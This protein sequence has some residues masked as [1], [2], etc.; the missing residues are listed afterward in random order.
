VASAF[1]G[2]HRGVK[3]LST[4]NVVLALFLV[5]FVFVAGP[6]KFILDAWPNALGDYLADLTNISSAT[7]AFGGADWMSEWTIFYW[8]WWLSWAPFVGTFIARISR[9]RTIRQFIVGVLL[10]PS[11]ASTLWFAM[12][13]TAIWKQA[14]GT[15]FSDSLAKGEEF[16]LFAMLESMPLYSLVSGLSMVLVAM[17]PGR[18]PQARRRGGRDADRPLEPVGSRAHAPRQR[19]RAPD[20]DRGAGTGPLV[21]GV[22]LR[23]KELS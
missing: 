10:I 5:V 12:G 21:Y 4:T 8:A 22:N 11:T 6:T 3:W 2:V 16:A 7:G 18:D 13:G 20:R 15:D 19:A 17:L 9:G 14:N 1:S 23:R